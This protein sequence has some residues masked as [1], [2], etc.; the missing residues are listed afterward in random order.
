MPTAGWPRRPST[1][2]VR[3]SAPLLHEYTSPDIHIPFLNN[4]AG[5]FYTYANIL[6][7]SK[8]LKK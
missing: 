5:F 8:V 3:Q 7:E 1:L 4:I 6:H 2:A